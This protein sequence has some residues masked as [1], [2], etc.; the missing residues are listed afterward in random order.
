MT[1]L[2]TDILTAK[3]S[4]SNL[5]RKQLSLVSCSL[6]ERAHAYLAILSLDLQDGLLALL[7]TLLVDTLSTTQCFERPT[8]AWR[9]H[10]RPPSGGTILTPST[11]NVSRN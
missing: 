9:T 8:N 2:T 10:R 11:T 4:D 7:D 1:L 6:A 5:L 3:H